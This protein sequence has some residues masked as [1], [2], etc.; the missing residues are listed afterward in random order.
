M[1]HQGSPLPLD[2]FSNYCSYYQPVLS[3]SLNTLAQTWT[4]VTF[5][6]INK[7]GPLK[8]NF[9]NDERVKKWNS[10]WSL[11]KAL[12]SAYKISFTFYKSQIPSHPHE[13]RKRV[14]VLFR[15]IAVPQNVS[16]NQ[17]SKAT[18]NMQRKIAKTSVIQM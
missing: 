13:S 18:K 6:S 10:P 17:S 2:I 9:T 5:V 16:T 11:I 1:S 12:Q 7:P 14:D 3:Y 15:S 8:Q 4:H